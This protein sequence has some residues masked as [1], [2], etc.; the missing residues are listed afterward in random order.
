MLYEVI[1]DLATYFELDKEHE[2]SKL[3]SAFSND[4]NNHK[5]W[6]FNLLRITYETN[7]VNHVYNYI[8]E[9]S[10]ESIGYGLEL[11]DLFLSEEIKPFI[12]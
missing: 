1:T 2:S 4:L 12:P 5:E 6:L 10:S 3:I 9:N 7:S 8:K 11:F